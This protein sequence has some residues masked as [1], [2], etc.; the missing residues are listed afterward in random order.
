MTTRRV[1]WQDFVV[2]AAIATGAQGVEAL[3][4]APE[5][6]KK[7]YTLTRLIV[8]LYLR[9]T[10]Y[11]VDSTDVQIASMGVGI[12]SDEAVT[13]GAF[14]DP[15]AEADNPVTGW[16][17]R[18]CGII[19]ENAGVQST[20]VHVDIRSQRKLMYGNPYLI[21]NNDAVSGTSF[22]ADIQGLVRVLYKLP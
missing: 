15:N 20:K 12:I 8:T 17:W 18:D 5:L 16:I 11:V 19:Q 6:Q 4:V 9:P 2:N 13:A 10:V 14:P 7:G 3:I 21:I 1:E 22:T